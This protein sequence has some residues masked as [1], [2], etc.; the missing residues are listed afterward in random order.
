[1]DLSSR[2]IDRT[3]NFLDTVD[4]FLLGKLRGQYLQEDFTG[5]VRRT[6]FEWVTMKTSPGVKNRIIQAGQR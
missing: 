5:F 1:M 3:N 6:H 4:N 2:T